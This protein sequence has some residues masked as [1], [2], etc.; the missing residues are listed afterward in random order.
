MLVDYTK[1][2][3]GWVETYLGGEVEAEVTASREV[4]LNQQR[5]LVGEADLDLGGESGGL[6]EVDEVLEGEGQG[7]GLG[8][9]NV[10][11]ELGLVHVGVAAEG[12]G[13]IT[14][15][16]VG[17]ELDTVLGGLNANYAPSTPLA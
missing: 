10:D 13:T 15:I 2:S 11:V 6:A 16:T 5:N 4:V 7:D 9:L 17:G 12:D 1:A 8:E 14:D 3:D